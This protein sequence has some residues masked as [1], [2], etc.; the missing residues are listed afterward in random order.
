MDEILPD[1]N[2]RKF[3]YPVDIHIVE[4]QKRQIAGMIFSELVRFLT[5]PT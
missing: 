2:N 1:I 3:P 5:K 4:K